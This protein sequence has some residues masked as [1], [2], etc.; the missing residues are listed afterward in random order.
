ITHRRAAAVA[1]HTGDQREARA[2]LADPVPA[3]RA[4]ALGAL[5][6]MG[7]ATDA[8]VAAGLADPDAAVRRRAC[9]L[10]VPHAAVDVVP[11]LADADPR[12]VEMAAWALGERGPA[13]AGAVEA[14]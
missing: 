5:A 6:R 14:L 10:A 13:A 8:D 11:L 1:G 7:A 4:T 9:A 3:V 12:V 2:L